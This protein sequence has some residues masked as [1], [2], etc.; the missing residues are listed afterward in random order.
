MKLAA[1]AIT[2]EWFRTAPGYLEKQPHR[3][4][5]FGNEVRGSK[6]PATFGGL[7]GSVARS[8]QGVR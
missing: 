7:C 8:M 6:I 5:R 1:D 4:F 2:A 3:W